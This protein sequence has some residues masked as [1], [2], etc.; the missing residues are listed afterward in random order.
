MRLTTC[1]PNHL[2]KVMG[3]CLITFLS[4]SKGGGPSSSSGTGASAG[5]GDNTLAREVSGVWLLSP[6]FKYDQRCNYLNPEVMRALFKVGE[7][8][9]FTHTD[10]PDGC[11][12]SWNGESVRLRFDKNSPF[13]STFQSEYAFTQYFR[14]TPKAELTKEPPTF[15]KEENN[16]SGPKTGGTNAQQGVPHG[17]AQSRRDSSAR[18]DTTRL[19]RPNPNKTIASEELVAN[20]KPYPNTTLVNN[21]GDKALWEPA[22]KTL[23]VL[24]LNH[25]F[26]ISVKTTGPDAQA[27]QG[28][29]ALARLII[30][31]LFNEQ[32]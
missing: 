23:H 25:V 2:P 20:K 16:L 3:I 10:Q 4:C 32:A 7:D 14:P 26:H 18:N 28:A 24:Y 17:E 27:R 8:A 1:F 11:S 31:K 6:D 22:Q 19:S 29:A 13:E 21:V 30:D 12:V 9:S 15:Y 5:T